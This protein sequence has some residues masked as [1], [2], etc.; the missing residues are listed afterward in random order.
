MLDPI[1][2]EV[3]AGG[4]SVRALSSSASTAEPLAVPGFGPVIIE[5]SG[6]APNGAARIVL[7]PEEIQVLVGR[8]GHV[9]YVNERWL[10][11]V[12]GRVRISLGDAD[13][14]D[15]RE[16]A[17]ELV[18][19]P[20]KLAEESLRALI[21]DLDAIA[22]GLTADLG[23][24]AMIET[25]LAATPESVLTELERVV[26]AVLESA[27]WVRHRPLGR[28]RE[29]VMAVPSDSPMTTARDV[30][31]L[32]MHPAS[33]ARV[34]AGGR[35]AAVQRERELDLDVPENRGVEG[36]FARLDTLIGSLAHRLSGEHERIQATRSAREA[37]VTDRGNLFT[38]QD[39]PRLRGI[40]RRKNRLGALEADLAAAR[41]CAALPAKL[42]KGQLTRSTQVE[43]HPGYWG[44]FRA[45]EQVG[46]IELG[47]PL[48]AFVPLDSLDALYETWCAIEVAKSAA[49]AFDATLSNVLRL[50]RD[51]WFVHL[52]RG[53]YG[54]IDLGEVELR[55]LFEP[56]Y[57]YNSTAELRKLHPGRPW[58]PDVVLEVRR[59]SR[60]VALHVFDAKHRLDAN[61]FASVPKEALVDVLAKY[62][63]SIGF[64]ESGLPAVMSAWV[65]FPGPV[66]HI[67]LNSPQMLG[68]SWPPARVRGGA[69]ALRPGMP[70][71]GAKLEELLR[72]V[73]KPWLPPHDQH[74]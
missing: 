7:G 9:R 34:S 31:W 12:A 65:L 16:A 43:T 42:P 62:P 68:E 52:P 5:G 49:R 45:S 50:D 25:K 60:P 2:L 17:V 73:T 47:V 38:E 46:A 15:T 37:F 13:I 39:V 22:P 58:C 21:A 54:R 19:R 72:V 71:G 29:R 61:R 40:E 32:A 66:P 14:D 74:G 6:L 64:C 18:V 36:L 27:V 67:E 4:L 28:V 44:L 33:R 3:R 23:G 70:E 48:P 51:R 11:A 35:G 63:D 57:A 10:S 26:G 30:R 53:E 41:A 59:D 55:L 20:T 1:Q 69:I 8:D 24:K 56:E